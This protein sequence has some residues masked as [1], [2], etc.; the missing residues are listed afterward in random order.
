MS[1]FDFTLINGVESSLVSGLH[2]T[3]ISGKILSFLSIFYKVVLQT[4]CSNKEKGGVGIW[5][6]LLRLAHGCTAGTQ[7]LLAMHQCFCL[8]ISLLYSN[9][10]KGGLQAVRQASRAGHYFLNTLW[11]NKLDHSRLIFKE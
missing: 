1:S 10:L 7:R 4:P 3:L 5:E 11:K 2:S 6:G 8:A 9:P